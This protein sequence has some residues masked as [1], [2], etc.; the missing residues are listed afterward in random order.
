MGI[1]GVASD[2]IKN[3]ISNSSLFHIVSCVYQE[4][5]EI[6]MLLSGA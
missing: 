3:E 1:K 5:E 6:D 4:F 2:N